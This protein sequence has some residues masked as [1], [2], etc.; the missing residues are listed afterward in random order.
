MRGIP[1]L[2]G[3]ILLLVRTAM[4]QTVWLAGDS[5]MALGGG[6]ANIPNTQGMSDEQQ[7]GV[8]LL[9]NSVEV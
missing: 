7:T 3:V 2:N 5:T 9:Y 1:V 4:T 8:C 6:G